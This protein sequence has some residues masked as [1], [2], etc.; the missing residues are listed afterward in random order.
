M[1]NS[2]VLALKSSWVTSP[3]SMAPLT[4]LTLLLP[5]PLRVS[6]I[7]C[8]VANLSNSEWPTQSQESARSRTHGICEILRNSANLNNKLSRK[9]AFLVVQGLFQ[10]CTA[11]H[12]THAKPLSCYNPDVTNPTGSHRIQQGAVLG[13]WSH[14]CK[15]T[16]A[17]S[18]RTW[19]SQFSPIRPIPERFRPGAS[20]TAW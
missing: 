20:R 9:P 11:T 5:A 8:R 18:P 16:R 15:E 2:Q 19:L 1:F 6:R 7:C 10:A 14:P 3:T 13:A 4:A 17:L 12:A